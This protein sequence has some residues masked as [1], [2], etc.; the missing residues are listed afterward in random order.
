MDS[1]KADL[2]GLPSATGA[3][4]TTDEPIRGD[5]RG[6]DEVMPR[7]NAFSEKS[8]A[9][10][11]LGDG[12]VGSLCSA[13]DSCDGQ[14]IC[15]APPAWLQALV[16]ACDTFGRVAMPLATAG[17]IFGIGGF[18]FLGVRDRGPWWAAG[19]A[20]VAV[21]FGLLTALHRRHE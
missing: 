3:T 12:D 16:D 2:G 18:V 5:E 6:V 20:T 7:H 14:E 21:L 13:T 10:D 17:I 19:A 11:E 9:C 8:G 15:A 1:F 4:G